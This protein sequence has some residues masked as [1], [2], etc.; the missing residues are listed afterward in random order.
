[1]D[2]ISDLSGNL[3]QDKQALVGV[4]GQGPDINYRHIMIPT[5]NNCRA[6]IVNIKGLINTTE[7]EDS[8]I[9]PLTA[10]DLPGDQTKKGS[11]PQTLSLLME[12]GLSVSEV[13]QSNLWADIC[14]YIVGGDSVLLVDGYDY[15]LILA[16]R[17]WKVRSIS[18]PTTEVETRGPKDCFVEDIMMNM[19]MI[20][21]RV[22]DHSLRFENFKV[23]DRTKTDITLAYIQ[24]LAN[25]S[26]LTEARARL[27]RIK[28]DGMINSNAVEEYIQDSPSPC[29]RRSNVRKDPT[30]LQRLCWKEEYWS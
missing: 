18:E 11:Q 5:L 2:V 20:R 29:S 3:D 25:D 30:R 10:K 16:N 15:A 6:L 22:R 26:L 19:A 7:L 23:G 27:G 12:S 21:R 4:L 17:G 14:D 24:S 1:M 8:V 28:I 13:K 9:A